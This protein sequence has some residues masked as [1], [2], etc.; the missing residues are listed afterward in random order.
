MMLVDQMERFVSIVY[1][2]AQVMLSNLILLR[3]HWGQ[4][5]HKLMSGVR[6]TE[7]LSELD[8][9]ESQS[10]WS[11]WSRSTWSHSQEYLVKEN[12]MVSS[13]ALLNWSC[14]CWLRCPFALLTADSLRAVANERAGAVVVSLVATTAAFSLIRNL[15]SS[16]CA[17]R[18][19]VCSYSSCECS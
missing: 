17:L 8:W 12:A 2:A 7:G 5:C 4:C 19:A 6:L 15:S 13:R 10:G 9:V 18:T 11:S 16:S 14:L 3:S 1:N